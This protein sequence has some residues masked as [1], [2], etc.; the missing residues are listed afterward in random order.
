VPQRTCRFVLRLV[1]AVVSAVPPWAAAQS[2]AS[3]TGRVDLSLDAVKNG[4]TRENKEVDN[5][6][7]LGFRG[8]E[9]AGGGVKAYFGLE[10][11]ISADTG[12]GTT[13]AYRH[14]YVGLGQQGAGVIGLGRIDS[15]T[16]TGSPLYSLVTKNIGFAV[17]DA[18]APAFSSKVLNARNRF[19]NSIS[20]AS[21][22]LAG[23]VVRA[24]V[25]LNGEDLAG[26][27]HEG[28]LKNLDIG[29]GYNA[30]RL[31]LGL[32]YGKN[33]RAG[34][35]LAN[36]FLEKWIAL[37][38][39]DFGGVSVYGVYGEDKYH[40]VVAGRRGTVPYWL[41]GVRGQFGTSTLTANYMRRAV[42]SDAQG[43]LA[44]LSASYAYGLSKRTQVYGI[45]DRE[46]PN[47]NVVDNEVRTLSFGVLHTF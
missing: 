13:P 38:A 8:V 7:R 37:A 10:L 18:G 43:R 32:G 27:A 41:G 46:D 36:D 6:S 12:L 3:I 4:S 26:V 25:A 9:D 1:L 31:G 45:F 23:F 47:S 20:Y 11:G 40:A 16:P 15:A 19:S 5:A 14:A 29:V 28:D 39:Y 17:H 24:R 22:D 33:R 44:K 21:P 30:G 42:Q 35:A 2:N 34:G